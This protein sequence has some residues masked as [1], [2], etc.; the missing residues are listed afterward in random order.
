MKVGKASS[1]S[2]GF[3]PNQKYRDTLKVCVFFLRYYTDT[4]TKALKV[5]KDKAA[6]AAAVAT[7]KKKKKKS[8]I[9][10]SD[11]EEDEVSCFWKPKMAW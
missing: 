8:K 7:K 3:K 6:K 4:A 1:S 10:V 11:A 2:L 9:Q 5:E